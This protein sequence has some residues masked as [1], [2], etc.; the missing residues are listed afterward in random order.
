MYFIV[1]NSQTTLVCML[2]LWFAFVKLN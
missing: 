1:S 2:I